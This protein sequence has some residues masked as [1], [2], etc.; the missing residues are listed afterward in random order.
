MSPRI[1]TAVFA[2]GIAVLFY[3]DR[4]EE[5]RSS[6]ALWLP[7]AW[8]FIGASRMVSTWLAAD[9]P[10]GQL[11][12]YVEGSPSDRLFLSIML[13]GALIVLFARAEKAG[14]IL[15]ANAPLLL[16]FAYCALSILWSDYTFVAF[17]RWTKA[18]GNLTM[19]L[20]ILTD[21][22][23]AT[24]F[25][26][27]FTRTGFLL[28]PLSILLIKYYPTLGRLF[29]KWTYTTTSIGVSTD[30]NGLGALCLVFGL[31]SVWRF[32][33]AFHDRD[34]PSRSRYLFGHG[35]V[36]A[37][38][39]WLFVASQSS[40]A[41]VCFILGSTLLLF[42]TRPGTERPAA[43]NLVVA[44][45]VVVPLLLGFAF[46]EAYT[47]AVEG[48]GRNVTLTGR[49][50]LWSDLFRVDLNQWLGAGFE[51]FWLGERAEYFWNKYDF[52]PNQAH[53]GYI[54]MYINLGWI[55]VALFA[56]VV[57][58]GYRNVVNM[59]RRDPNA[60]S[61]RLAFFIVALLYSVT[62]AAF[63]VTH[64]VWIVFLLAVAAVPPLRH[65]RISPVKVPYV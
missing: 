32:I 28:I 10:V 49:T 6:L 62:E 63:K 37:M 47:Y 24:A 19:V 29:S 59:Y 48:L 11:D 38:A 34:N 23:P 13:G 40:T 31:V 8:I 53:N 39:S 43:V 1:A 55:G 65:R 45:I 27:V 30:K 12:Q 33:D 16:F 2:A 22:Q 3:L 42:T 36:L 15:R 9:L 61:I 57:A 60:G 56:I 17:K 41:L 5:P 26:R 7:A 52:H 4:D 18:L 51:S 20:V 58:A 54:E 14:A 64:P 25:R 50:A 21:P 35:A 46:Q 44:T